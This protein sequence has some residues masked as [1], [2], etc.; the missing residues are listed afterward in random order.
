MLASGRGADRVKLLLAGE[1]RD[2]CADAPACGIE[3]ERLALGSA[4]EPEGLQRR[5]VVDRERDRVGRLHAV[6][7]R[8]HVGHATNYV[9]G[10]ATGGSVG[11]HPLADLHGGVLVADA[12][13]DPRGLHSRHDVRLAA[14]PRAIRDEDV[15]EANASVVNSDFDFAWCRRHASATQSAESVRPRSWTHHKFRLVAHCSFTC[16]LSSSTALGMPTGAAS[17]DASCAVEWRRRAS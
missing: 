6:G 16:T 8:E 5:H 11:D 9:G 12:R 3:E 1:I 10:V 7:E 17:A 2:R 14:S 4:G 15:S 13:D